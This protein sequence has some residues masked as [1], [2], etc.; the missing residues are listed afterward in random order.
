M[1]IRNSSPVQG[2]DILAIHGKGSSGVFDNLLPFGQDIVAGS[3]VRVED[4]VRFTK[5]SF[6]V[7]F[8]RLVVVLRAVSLVT[9]SLQLRS[10]G[11]SCLQSSVSAS[12]HLSPRR[13]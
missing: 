8:D 12:A 10:I 13:H 1:F 2:L 9:G 6:S 11:F 4:R 3:A 5:D 7:K